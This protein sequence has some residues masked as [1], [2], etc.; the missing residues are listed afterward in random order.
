MDEGPARTIDRFL[1]WL[2]ALLASAE[3]MTA[4]VLGYIDGRPVHMAAW[5]TTA[6]TMVAAGYV[7]EALKNRR[8]P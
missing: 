4:A 5:S 8:R 6:V 7:A 3:A 2:V 1:V